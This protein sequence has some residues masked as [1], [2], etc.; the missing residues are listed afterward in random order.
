[1]LLCLSMH[2]FLSSGYVVDYI[3]NMESYMEQCENKDKPILQCDGKCLLA[4]KISSAQAPVDPDAEV[5]VSLSIEYII[6]VFAPELLPPVRGTTTTGD[7]PSHYHFTWNSSL[8]KPPVF[9]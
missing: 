6:G 2:M 7:T 8:L 1:M 3:V 4:E 9:G 5:L